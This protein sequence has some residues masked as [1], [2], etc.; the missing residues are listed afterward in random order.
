MLLVAMGVVTSEGLG[1]TEV[2]FCLFSSKPRIP[3][4]P[5]FP[6]KGVL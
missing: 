3:E 4:G 2:S 1:I 6:V 5:P